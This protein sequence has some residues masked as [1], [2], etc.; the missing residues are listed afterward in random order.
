MHREIK[1]CD[2][3]KSLYYADTSGMQS[4]CPECAHY[5]YEYDNCEHHFENGSCIKCHWDGNASEYIKSKKKKE[6]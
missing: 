2:E 4:L 1:E 6:H 5:L 3:C